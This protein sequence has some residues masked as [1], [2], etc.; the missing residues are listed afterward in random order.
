MSG[1]VILGSGMAGWGAAHRLHAHGVRPVMLEKNGYIG[2][3]TTTH[4]FPGGW[5]FDEGPHVSFTKDERF[6]AILAANVGDQYRRVAAKV[7]NYWR[8]HWIRHPANSYL[9]GLP[10]DLIVRILADFVEARKVENPPIRTYRDWLVATYGRTYAETFPME[11]TWKYHTTT[12]DNMSTDWL[13]PRL[14]RPSLEQVLRGA[15]ATQTENVHYVEDFRYPDRGGFAAYV[16]P[17]APLADVRLGHK[18][19]AIDPRRRSIRCA[20]GAQAGY[21]RLVSSVPLPDLIPM[22]EGAPREVLDAASR[23]SC[24]ICVLVNIGVN[25]A[26]LLDAT[27][28]YFYD[29][30]ICFSRA[31]TPHLQSPHTCPPGCGSLQ[32]ECYFSTKYRPLDRPPEDLI[33]PVIAGFRTCG[34]LRETDTILFRNAMVIPYANIIFDLDRAPAV[35]IVHGYLRDIGVEYCGRYGD[36]GYLW[37]DESFVSGENAAQRVIESMGTPARATA[38]G[39]A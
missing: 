28:T 23:L 26:D 39:A 17:F 4:E 33:E 8:G 37:T 29:R 9:H 36:W 32:A 15:L 5:L 31:S 2:G 13:G 20:N 16:R 25:R 30:D 38:R 3:H 14:N 12:A 24:S 10:V 1:V 19:V 22:I 34:A 27:W 21:D 6:R 18:V 7:N 35:A 11:Y